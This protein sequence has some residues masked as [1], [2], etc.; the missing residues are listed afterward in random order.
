MDTYVGTDAFNTIMHELGH[1]MGLKHGHQAENGNPA[2]PSDLDDNEF[3]V[4]T[5]RSYLGAD[6]SG[7]GATEAVDGSSPQSYM[8]CDIAALQAMYGV[9]LDWLSKTATYSWDARTGLQTLKLDGNIVT[10]AVTT[11]N[12]TDDKIFLTV[13]TQ[14]ATAAYD[15]SNFSDN[16][17]DDMNPGRW[18]M[19]SAA[20]LAELNSLAGTP[21]YAPSQA[22]YSLFSK[23]SSGVQVVDSRPL[24]QQSYAPGKCLQFAALPGQHELRDQRPHGRQ[25]QR[26]HHRQRS[27]ERDPRRRRRRHD[28]RRRRHQRAVRRG[29]Q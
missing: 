3:S 19:F 13:W 10:P 11:A 21:Q 25:R 1:A 28:Q 12:K 18:M 16:Q 4:M 23:F 27:R 7:G 26:H 8:M 2:L 14:G 6:L 24:V 17:T 9:N 22:Y 15:L 20:Q 29:R 5:Y